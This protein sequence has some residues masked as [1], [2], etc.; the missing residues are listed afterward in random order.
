MTQQVSELPSGLTAQQLKQLERDSRRENMGRAWYK[1]SRNPLSLVGAATILLVVLLAIFAAYV[2]PYPDHAT[3]PFTDFANASQAPSREH[4]FGT[5]E[6]GRDIFSRTI[7]GLRFSLSMGIIVLVLVVPVGV[8]LGLVAG[9]FQGTRIDTIIM[10][11]TD[12]FL[13]VPSLILA[14]AIASILEPN[15][16]HSMIAIS[17]MWWPWYTRLVYGQTSALRNEFFVSSAEVT[18]ASTAHIL[19][20]EILPNTIS[21]IFT[22]MSLDM[23]WVIIIGASLSFVGLGVQPPKPGL[24][25]MVAS[26]AKYLPDQWWI[27]LFPALAIVVVVLG[28]NLFGDGLRDL[29]AAEEV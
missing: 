21:S 15:L 19:F 3:K 27:S 16:S 4:L 26:G 7:F 6:I 24:G 18:G 28:F 8:L 9:Y 17:L 22:K 20:R 13:S 12:I 23:G 25:T 29:F 10:R 1:F 11:I 5:D 2:T 14:L